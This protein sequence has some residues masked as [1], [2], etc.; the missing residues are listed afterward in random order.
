MKALTVRVQDDL[1]DEAVV[2]LESLG[3]NLTTAVNVF[4]RQRV[5]NRAI[6]SPLA[7]DAQRSRERSDDGD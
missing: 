7:L 5:I 6:P 3:L 4:L 2:L 1:H